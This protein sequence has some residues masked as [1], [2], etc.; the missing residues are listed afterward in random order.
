[1]KIKTKEFIE[2]CKSISNA[3]DS[4]I[5]NLEI[6]AK[7]NNLYLNVTNKEIYVG[8]KYTLENAETFRA[9][10]NAKLF[11][12][13]ISNITAEDF[14]LSVADNVVVVKFKNGAGKTSSYKLSMIYENDKLIELPRIKLN[15][16]TVEMSI[17][18]D[19]LKS[20]VNINSKEV[21]K[22]KNIDVNELQKL[23]YLTENGCFSFTTGAC[24]NSFTLEKPI[25]LLLNDRIV[26]LFKL[27]KDDVKFS[28]GHDTF[29]NGAVQAKAVFETDNIY[30]AAIVTDD[31]SLLNKIQGPFMAVQKYIAENYSNKI[32]LSVNEVASAIS[33]LMLFT[34]NSITSTDMTNIKSTITI[35]GNEFIIK[36][37]LGNSETITIENG[38]YVEDTYELILN[39]SDLKLVLDSCKDSH[40][41]FNCG[42]KKSVVITRGQVS[43]LIPEGIK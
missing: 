13:L 34:K 22:V 33:R 20:I 16:P 28:F 43:N 40:I 8:I 14:D 12:E 29:S 23:Y 27:F 32:V 36:D 31:E 37:I 39:I 7:E 9:V 3:L 6:K 24:M 2:A 19:I 30:V 4:N 5:T 11:L 38:S 17:E 42:N 21:Q 25:K 1:M 18:N 10:V 41:T 15:T 26:K 35:S